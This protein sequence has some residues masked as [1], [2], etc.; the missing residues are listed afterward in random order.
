MLVDLKKLDY[1]SDPNSVLFKLRNTLEECSKQHDYQA[2][3]KQ[4]ERPANARGDSSL[5]SVRS[6]SPN[7]DRSLQQQ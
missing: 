5:G 6:N 3:Q 7:F 4:T 1:F 2:R